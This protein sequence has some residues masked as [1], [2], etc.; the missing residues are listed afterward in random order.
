MYEMYASM[1]AQAIREKKQVTANYDGHRREF[2]PHLLG[3]RDG[4]LHMLGYQ[5]AGTS[6]QGPVTGEWKCFVVSNLSG[7][8]VRTGPW[9][10]D[11]TNRHSR[12]QQCIDNVIVT[13]AT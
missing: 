10:T 1:L 11:P 13:V 6:S 8:V 9:Q 7:V 3:Y 4:V 2:C 5:F 12:S